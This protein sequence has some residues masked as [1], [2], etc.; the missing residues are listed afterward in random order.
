ML[1]TPATSLQPVLMLARDRGVISQEHY[2]KAI[3][4]LVDIGQEFISVDPPTLAMAWELDRESGEGVGRRFRLASRL[5]G[6]TNEN[7]V[8]HCSVAVAFLDGLW[9]SQNLK[10]GDYQVTSHLLRELLKD[11]TE[12]YQPMLDFLDRRLANRTNF[13]RYLRQSTKGHFLQ[14]PQT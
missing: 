3:T 11:R 14:W 13:R 9:S 1:G 6:G 12:D 2:T 5:L 7:S 4:D 10:A 8:S